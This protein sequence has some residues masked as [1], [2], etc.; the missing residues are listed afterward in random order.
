M[1]SV[2]SN[3]LIQ[4]REKG[5]FAPEVFWERSVNFLEYTFFFFYVNTISS[6]TPRRIKR[7]PYK[8]YDINDITENTELR[9]N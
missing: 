2:H 4:G 9:D 1:Y 6:F 7:E 5:L 8:L 3:L